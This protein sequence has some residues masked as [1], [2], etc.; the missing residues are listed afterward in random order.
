VTTQTL[1]DAMDTQKPRIGGAIIEQNV[2]RTRHAAET[3]AVGYH[4]AAVLLS[5]ARA[6][7]CASR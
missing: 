5:T 6:R 3:L 7:G 4:N 2:K 1:N